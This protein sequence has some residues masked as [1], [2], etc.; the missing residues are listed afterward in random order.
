[1][2]RHSSLKPSIRLVVNH[3]EVMKVP[4]ASMSRNLHG[5]GDAIR[6]L[7]L[8][9]AYQAKLTRNSTRYKH[10]DHALLL[11]GYD[12]YRGNVRT[13]AGYAPVKGMCTEARS[14]TISEGLDFGAV[15]VIAHEMGHRLVLGLFLDA[16]QDVC[17]MVWCGNGEGLI[18]SA[19]PAL[20]YSYCG[21]R[22]WCKEGQCVAAATIEDMVVRHGEWS[23]WNDIRR[24]DCASE[25]VPCQISG[26]IRLRRSTRLCDKPL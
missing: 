24:G 8:F 20:E 17:K 5:G 18:R 14:C 4:P 21:H 7:D 1:L 15:F 12:L 3:Y 2:F 22:K 23:S 9:C 16:F 25:C 10:W 11:T 13:V 19:H 6:L 26:Q